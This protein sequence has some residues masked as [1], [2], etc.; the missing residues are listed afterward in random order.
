M[1]QAG[2]LER[3]DMV[4]QVRFLDREDTGV[5]GLVSRYGGCWFFMSGF[6]IGRVLVLPARFLDREDTGVTGR[7]SR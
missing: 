5:T 3:E 1:F 2:F 6:Y 4:Q 7:V